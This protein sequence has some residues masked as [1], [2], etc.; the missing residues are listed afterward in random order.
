[1]KYSNWSQVFANDPNIDSYDKN[2]VDVANF[3]I[4]TMSANKCIE[5]I[6][7]EPNLMHLSV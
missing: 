5:N 1:M 2:A 6:N 4:N 3:T 7:K